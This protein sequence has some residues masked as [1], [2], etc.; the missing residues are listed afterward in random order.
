VNC[1]TNPAFYVT[2]ALP[3]VTTFGPTQLFFMKKLFSLTLAG[4]LLFCISGRAQVNTD[5]LTIVAKISKYQLELGK[6]QN[7]IAKKTNTKQN[8]SLI[9]QQSATANATA[10]NNLDAN[11]QD[12]KDARQADNA[13]STAKGDSRRARRAADKLN[14]LN[15][16]ILDLQNKIADQQSKLNQFTHINYA[17]VTALIPAQ[18]DTTQHF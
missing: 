4:I 10:A 9:A 2:I 14:D 6:L 13:A 8:D 12:K 7:T 5:S 1:I 16:N 18:A 3:D 17:P 15:K 11:P